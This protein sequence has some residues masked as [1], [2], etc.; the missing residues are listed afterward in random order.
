MRK[1]LVWILSYKTVVAVWWQMVKNDADWLRR[2]RD[3]A[4]SDAEIRS[5]RAARA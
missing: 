5:K 4:K 2:T 3:I 1:L